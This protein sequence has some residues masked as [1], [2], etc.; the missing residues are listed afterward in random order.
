LDRV[1]KIASD[2][3]FEYNKIRITS[4]KTRW[5][6]CSSKKNL[7][8]SFYLIGAPKKVIDYV[9]V[10]E[11]AHLSEM[12]HSKKFWRVVEII[13]PKYKK[14]KKWLKDNWNSLIF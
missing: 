10:H 5:W 14:H 13:M 1:I 6:S 4:A 12:N 7:N 2:Y 9:I 8:F 3:G 11:L